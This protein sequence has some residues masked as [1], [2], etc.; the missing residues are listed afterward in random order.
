MRRVPPR[1]MLAAAIAIAVIMICAVA[2]TLPHPRNTRRTTRIE[3]LQYVDHPALNEAHAAFISRLSERGYVNGMGGVEIVTKNAQ[4]DPNAMQ[5]IVLSVDPTDCDVI[6]TLATPISQAVKRKFG[7]SQQLPVVYGV[8]TDPVSAGL[9]ESLEKPGDNNTATS[10]QWPYE[11]QMRIIREIFPK[12]KRVGVLLNPGEV[13]TQFAMKKTR[14]AALKNSLELVERPISS[15]NDVQAAVLSLPEVDVMYVPA[16]N[17]AMAAAPAIIK[18]A[19]ERGIPTIAGDPGTFE[20]GALAGVGVSYK[21]L[22]QLSADVVVRILQMEHAGVIPVVTVQ[23]PMIMVNVNLAKKMGV[24][25]PTS[26]LES[27][28]IIKDE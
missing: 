21:E 6:F 5:N 13:N 11:A 26:V 3:I 12:A 9:V 22:G 2:V 20:A 19:M 14:E 18:L 1:L 10:D 16:D 7:H 27:A 8:I 4:G 17:T 24:S 15:L 28:I 25:I 23:K